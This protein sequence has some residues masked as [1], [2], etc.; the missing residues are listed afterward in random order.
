MTSIERKVREF[1]TVEK[2]WR[3]KS[4]S[5]AQKIDVEISDDSWSRTSG[6]N[7]EDKPEK[8]DWQPEEQ[9]SRSKGRFQINCIIESRNLN[10]EFK[11]KSTER[12][13]SQGERER[14]WFE[15]WITFRLLVLDLKRERWLDDLERESRNLQRIKHCP[16]WRR[17]QELGR[18]ARTERE[19]P[20][21]PSPWTERSDSLWI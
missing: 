7:W 19:F 4:I 6:R 12:L 21:N 13:R 18:K 2:T 16:C 3:S 9:D 15:S 1:Y 20:H 8:R 17:K 11:Y 5:D 14:M 10:K